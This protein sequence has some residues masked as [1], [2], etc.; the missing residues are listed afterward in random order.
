VDKPA[1]H[2]GVFWRVSF[3]VAAVIVVQ[4][5]VCGLAALPV[6]L[7]WLELLRYL[8][9]NDMLRAAVLSAS[10]VPSYALFAAALM[11]FTP[12]AT[13][14]TRARTP[15]NAE[16]RITEMSWPLMR[17]ARYMVAIHMV[18]ILAGPIFRASPVFT[19]YLRLNGARLGQRVYVNTLFISDHNMLEFGDDVVIGSE[20]HL[21]GHTVER[22]FVKTG[23]VRLAKNVTIGLG[24]VVDIDVEAGEGCTVG[25]MSLVPK[26]TKLEA[27]A[28]YAGI[29]VKRIG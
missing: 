9:E 19:F 26:H 20:V 14:L 11:I 12:A 18:R 22:G 13:A 16:L 8:P 29:P 23:T 21:S 10:I 6:L 1:S 17:W 15:Q 28:V 7:L 27:G 25:A 2:I 4:T 24:A 3:T 5:I